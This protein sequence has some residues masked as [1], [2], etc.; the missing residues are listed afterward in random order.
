MTLQLD[1]VTCSI[2]S[3][4]NTWGR[5]SHKCVEIGKYEHKC[6]CNEGYLLAADHFTC[7]SSGMF[8]DLFWRFTNLYY[9]KVKSFKLN[10]FFTFLI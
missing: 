9:S 10:F 7:K 2:K 5:C 1:N 8:E 4:C 6:I 3:P